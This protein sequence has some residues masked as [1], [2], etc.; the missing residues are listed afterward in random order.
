METCYF[1]AL[2]EDCKEIVQVN[3]LSK[4]ILC[5]KCKRS[6]VLPYDDKKLVK[7]L[8][9]N[10]IISWNMERQ[11]GR[12]LRLTDGKYFCPSCGKYGL[13]FEHGDIL[14]D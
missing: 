9:K 11:L 4:R 13:L 1:P 5:P 8:G 10:E 2:C 7:K 3:L 14:W 12:M 6:Q